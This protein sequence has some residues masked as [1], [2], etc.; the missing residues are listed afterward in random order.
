AF[1]DA[2][3]FADFEQNLGP[4]LLDAFFHLR[5]DLLALALRNRR[6]TVARTAQEARYAVGIL[7]QVPSVV[8]EFHLDQHIARENT[9]LRNG[10]FAALDLDDFFRRNKDTAEFVLQACTL[11]AFQ[12]RLVHTFFHARIHMDDVP[13]FA[14]AC[15]LVPAQEQT[16]DDPFQRFVEDPE[17]DGHDR[18]EHEHDASHLGGFLAGGPHDALDLMIGIAHVADGAT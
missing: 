15:P 2:D 6:G 7:H 11:D 12:Q 14:H 3:G 9:A 4:W 18:D 8:G 1:L 17:N 10:L 16:I 5:E 13:A